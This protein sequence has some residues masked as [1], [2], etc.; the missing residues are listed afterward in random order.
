[1]AKEW[2]VITSNLAFVSEETE[3]I[4]DYK[5]SLLINSA[6]EEYESQDNN[7][8]KILSFMEKGFRNNEDKVDRW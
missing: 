3:I 1:M 2:I 7:S 4:D 6:I 5:K 8:N